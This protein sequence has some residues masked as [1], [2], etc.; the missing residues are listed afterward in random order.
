MTLPK[1][2]LTILYIQGL[3]SVGRISR[4]DCLSFPSHFCRIAIRH[5]LH[6]LSILFFD[7]SQKLSGL[8][9]SVHSADRM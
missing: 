3:L 4:L 7:D 6:C 5:G 1:R 2:L 9:Y 8:N